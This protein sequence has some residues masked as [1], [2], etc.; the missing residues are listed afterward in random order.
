VVV[1]AGPRKLENGLPKQQ[2]SLA[3]GCLH[4]PGY[5]ENNTKQCGGLALADFAALQ[6][7]QFPSAFEW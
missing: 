3:V 5:K 4:T 2:R 6:L 7:Q 1:A